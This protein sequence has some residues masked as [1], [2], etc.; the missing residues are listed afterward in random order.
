MENK[1]NKLIV[2]DRDDT[3]NYDPGY[4]SDP[5][6]VKLL[7][8]VV[9]GLTLLKNLGFIFVVATNQS[10]VGREYFSEEQL[11]AVHQKL[12]T[13]LQE[14]GITISDFFVCPHTPQDNCSCRKPK[15][16]LIE[17]ALEKYSVLPQNTYVIGD[18]M[19]D[20]Q[21]GTELN[22]QGILLEQ[23]GENNL[24]E[25]EEIF[26]LPNLIYHAKNLKQ[27]AEFIAQNEFEKFIE[28]KIIVKEETQK[29]EMFLQ[30]QKN[31][32]IVFTNGCFDVLHPG[33]LQ[34]LWQAKTLGDILLVG[35]N[36]DKSVKNLKGENRP[37]NKW[38]DRAI[39]LAALGSVSAVVEFD[40]STPEKLIASVQPHIHV[41]GGDYTA[42]DLPEFSLLKKMG[43]EIVI[44]PF[45][46]G[47]STTSFLQ[48]IG[49]E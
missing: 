41:K 37:V 32:K 12:A 45:R 1:I 2:L 16:G 35:L 33:H 28:Q 29:L 21:A 17:Q 19:R 23:H 30:K 22:I 49:K 5:Q 40:E 8:Q 15:S 48:R 20:I 6:Q 26:S 43:S 7:P 10:G 36:S 38:Q 42:E 18:R 14:Q 39:A 34:Y 24:R 3:L 9:E 47:Y 25:K 44:L 31:K 11:T 4:L 27:A 46:Q 13:L